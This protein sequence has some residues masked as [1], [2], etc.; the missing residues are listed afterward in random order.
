MNRFSTSTASPSE[1][2]TAI[3]GAE[4]GL[5]LDVPGRDLDLVELEGLV[6]EVARQDHVWRGLVGYSDEQRHFASLHRDE[7]LDIWLLCWTVGNDT[8]WHDHDISSGAVHVVSGALN[9]SCPR[10]AGDPAERTVPVGGTFSF[11]PDHIHR[12]TGAVE[13]SISIHAYSPALLQLGQYTVDGRG[14]LRRQSISY[15]EELRAFTEP[16]AA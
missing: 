9:E 8:G 2:P 14:L 3:A 13:H 7:H 15:T 4:L 12:I 6:E 10:L 5:V 16:L 11:G 1:F